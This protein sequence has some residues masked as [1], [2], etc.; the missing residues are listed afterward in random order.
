MIYKYPYTIALHD[1]DAAAVIFSANLLRICHQAYETMMENCGFAL[2]TILN[3]NVYGLPLVHVEGDFMKPLRTGDKVEIC[4]QV[5]ELSTRSFR[6]SYELQNV[7]G[8]LCATAATVHVCV[9]T[10]TMKSIELPSSLRAA[11][12]RYL[13]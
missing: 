4:V 10:A 6:M 11:L 9:D 13:L 8:E 1:T 12:Q 2:G 5:S 7:K 3:E